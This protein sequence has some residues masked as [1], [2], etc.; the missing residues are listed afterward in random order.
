MVSGVVV[1]LVPPGQ[2]VLRYARPPT[3]SP[4]LS[5][6]T[7]CASSVENTLPSSGAL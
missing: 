6:V 3:S 2:W 1:L 5:T 4:S 7:P